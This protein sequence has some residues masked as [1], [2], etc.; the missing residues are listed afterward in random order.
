MSDRLKYKSLLE[1]L[2]E[3]AQ[4]ISAVALVLRNGLIIDSKI[5]AHLENDEKIGAMAA[6]FV[7]STETYQR[8]RKQE[9]GRRTA[10]DLE[11]SN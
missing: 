6:L 11:E 4:D 7:S 2:L 3:K 5:R 8:P 10:T 9:T 1:S